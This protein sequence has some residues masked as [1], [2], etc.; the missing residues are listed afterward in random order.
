V[1]LMLK[2]L[3]QYRH[4]MVNSIK[5]EIRARFARSSLGALWMIFNPLAQVAIYALI[6]TNIMSAR[7]PDIDNVYSFAIYL[8][9][10]ILAWSLFADIIT[11]CLNLFVQNG[12]LM[13]KVMFPKVVLPAI[14]VGTAVVDNLM[15]FLSILLIFALAGHVPSIH[16]LW[17]PI[18]TLSV[19]ALAVGIGLILGILNVFIRDF[20]QAIPIILQI[21]FWFTPIVY[22]L[23]IIPERYQGL[24]ALNPM[25]PIVRSYQD[26]LVYGRAPHLT[27]VFVI[28]IVSAFLMLCGFI[29]F[30]RASEE[31]ADVL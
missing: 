31:M 27:D 5:T 26:I 13:K 9:A 10:G 29:L 25:Y 16:L 14:A 7:I 28:V 6:F 17:L 18:L 30:M 8:T 22:P 20:G 15:L 11:R 24:L 21:G 1:F 2:L 12:N 19:V 3:W 4:F 23:S